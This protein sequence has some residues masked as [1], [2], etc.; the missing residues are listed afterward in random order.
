MGNHDS[1]SDFALERPVSGPAK[2]CPVLFSMSA[3]P[4]PESLSPT[5]LG[6]QAALRR[7]HSAGA[8]VQGG[9]ALAL[10]PSPSN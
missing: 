7:P 3:A 1:Y 4:Y 2:R 10:K 9:L 5:R 6:I 8:A